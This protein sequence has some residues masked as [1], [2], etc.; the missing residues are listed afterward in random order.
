MATTCVART[1]PS[2]FRYKSLAEVALLKERGSLQIIPLLLEERVPNFLLP[3]L[4]ALAHAL[5]LADCHFR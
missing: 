2:R 4:L 3:T 5:V 1:G